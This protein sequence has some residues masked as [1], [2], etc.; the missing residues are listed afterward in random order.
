[1]VE[2]GNPPSA[3]NHTTVEGYLK[4]KEC[5]HMGCST[6]T[7][8]IHELYNIPGESHLTKVKE[9]KQDI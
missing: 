7:A 1:M 8:A 2:C 9:L 3:A 6:T 4:Y 5:S